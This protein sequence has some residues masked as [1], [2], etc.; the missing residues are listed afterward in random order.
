MLVSLVRSLRS[1]QRGFFICLMVLAL[2]AASCSGSSKHAAKASGK[3]SAG[4][5][6]GSLPTA[7]APGGQVAGSGSGSSKSGY[8]S[9]GSSGGSAASGSSSA[10]GT[11]ASGSLNGGSGTTSGAQGAGGAC[12]SPPGS[13]Q[14][15][16]AGSIKIARIINNV[17]SGG[18]VTPLSE[19]P[20][21][22]SSRRTTSKLS[23]QSTP[24]V[25]S[26]VAN[27]FPFL[28]MTTRL[29]RPFSSSAA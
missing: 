21:R 19:Y 11:G 10:G 18:S 9:A 23:I 28:S 4:S 1:G 15:V 8:G 13:D 16:S 29:T 12:V 6:G 26:P 7:N 3:V 24:P 2:V 5:R 20:H 14:G 25:A 17:A 27:S 22:A